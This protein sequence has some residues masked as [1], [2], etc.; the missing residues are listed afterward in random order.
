MKTNKYKTVLRLAKSLTK[1]TDEEFQLLKK[2]N[3]DNPWNKFKDLERLVNNYVNKNVKIIDVPIEKYIV[4]VLRI[5]DF[6]EW[7]G[8]NEK[9]EIVDKTL[10]SLLHCDEIQSFTDYENGKEYTLIYNNFDMIKFLKLV[11]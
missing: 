2:I 1:I 11:L 10:E 3:N 7:L 9:D 4:N 5:N 6:D 8:E